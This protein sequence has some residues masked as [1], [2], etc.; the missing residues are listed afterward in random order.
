MFRNWASDPEV[1]RFMLY[2]I[3]NTIKDTKKRIEEWMH[4]FEKTAPNSAVFAI[5]LK[6]MAM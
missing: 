2:D 5:E 3:C 6:M 1:V 4:Y